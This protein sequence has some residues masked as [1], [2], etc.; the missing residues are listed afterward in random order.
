PVPIENERRTWPEDLAIAAE[1]LGED[2]HTPCVDHGPEHRVLFDRSIHDRFNQ[3]AQGGD[4]DDRLFQR[5]AP[6]FHCGNTDTQ[7]GIRSRTDPHGERIHILQTQARFGQC[8][9]GEQVDLFGVVEFL[10]LILAHRDALAIPADRDTAKWRCRAYR[11]DRCH[12]YNV[13]GSP[14]RMSRYFVAIRYWYFELI[15][16]A[17]DRSRFVLAVLYSIEV[18]TP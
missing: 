11:E 16:S 8:F 6:A 4:P 13:T 15:R 18:I 17:V 7:A 12:R 1:R 14:C 9:G 2:L 5:I 10:A 3:D